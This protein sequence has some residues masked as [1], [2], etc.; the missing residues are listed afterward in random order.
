MTDA[1]STILSQAKISCFVG[2]E[3]QGVGRSAFGQNI[4]RWRNITVSDGIYWY[5]VVSFVG[6]YVMGQLG[7][8]SI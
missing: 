1:V 2:V 5:L 6:A 3:M 4:E 7:E 8:W